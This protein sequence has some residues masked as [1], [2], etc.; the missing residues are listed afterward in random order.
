MSEEAT[1]D[2][3]QVP[4]IGSFPRGIDQTVRADLDET[5]AHRP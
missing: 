1:A 3:Y 4:E 2:T 5:V